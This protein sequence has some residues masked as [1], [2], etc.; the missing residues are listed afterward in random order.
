MVAQVAVSVVLL[1]GAG[2][3]LRTVLALQQVNPGFDP[4]Q[5]LGATLDLN[6]SK[7][8]SNELIQQFHQRLR[9]R[10]AAPARHPAGRFEPR[11]SAGRPPRLRL[12]FP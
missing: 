6:F 12:R 1:V 7:Y 10:L 8:T 5:V 2:L 9:E 11:V 4:E 3:M